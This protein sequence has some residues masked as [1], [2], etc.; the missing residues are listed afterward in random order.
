MTEIVKRLVKFLKDNKEDAKLIAGALGIIR[1]Y[2]DKSGKEPV[3]FS[4]Q[5]T[6]ND[7]ANF[8]L[9]PTTAL[10]TIFKQ[11]GGL[12]SVVDF[13]KSSDAEIRKVAAR[14]VGDLITKTG[15]QNNC[16]FFCLLNDW[17]KYT[18]SGTCRS[19]L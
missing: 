16:K 11:E 9:I 19:T 2:P 5:K 1:F 13:L 15:S 12:P 6:E 4:F 17:S 14:F 8:I 10:E 3:F 18:F 7:F